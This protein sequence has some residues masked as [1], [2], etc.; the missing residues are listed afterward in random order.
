MSF[1]VMLLVVEHEERASNGEA[2]VA[3]NPTVQ[4]KLESF[5]RTDIWCHSLYH[6]RR[7]YPLQD[8]LDND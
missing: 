8:R 2:R 1:D 3:E 4:S 6:C 7:R 5:H